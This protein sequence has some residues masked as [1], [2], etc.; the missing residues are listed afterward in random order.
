[1]NHELC[2]IY[3][4]NYLRCALVIFQTLNFE[5]CSLGKDPKLG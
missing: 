4:R 1:M 5:I 3:V 2:G